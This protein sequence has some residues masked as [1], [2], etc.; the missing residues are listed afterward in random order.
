MEDRLVEAACCNL[1]GLSFLSSLADSGRTLLWSAYRLYNQR[2]GG[3]RAT[4]F[5][6]GLLFIP[7]MVN[8]AVSTGAC[9]MNQTLGGVVWDGRQSQMS[10]V[11]A[12][13]CARWGCWNWLLSLNTLGNVMDKV[14]QSILFF[15]GSFPRVGPRHNSHLY[16]MVA[17]SLSFLLLIIM[18]S[19][20]RV[21]TLTPS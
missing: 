7:K 8:S 6:Y 2:A 10:L 15:L 4:W 16:S 21:R 19:V 11:P 13:S 3:N 14:Q 5:S 18:L 20:E 12:C 17:S 1:G 9:P